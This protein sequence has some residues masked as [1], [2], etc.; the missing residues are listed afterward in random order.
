MCLTIIIDTPIYDIAD[1]LSF[2]LKQSER[3]IQP[4]SKTE[5]RFE[6]FLK[7]TLAQIADHFTNGPFTRRF[8][9]YELL[10]DPFSPCNRENGT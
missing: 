1:L 7:F 5:E 4:T 8:I 3:I 6:R 10:R 2:I 9:R